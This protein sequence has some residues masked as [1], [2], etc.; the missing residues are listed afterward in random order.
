MSY[1]PS[2]SRA[3]AAPAIGPR[4][5]TTREEVLHAILQ[6][7]MSY[8]LDH[9]GACPDDCPDCARLRRIEEVLL[10]PFQVE[11]YFPGRPAA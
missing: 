7:Q 11:F 6:E 8:L 9:A 2:N 10:E 1:A 5:R 4:V 3:T